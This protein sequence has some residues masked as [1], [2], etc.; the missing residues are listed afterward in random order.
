[1]YT[2]GSMRG[3]E[4]PKFQIEPFAFQQLSEALDITRRIY[5]SRK[6]AEQYARFADETADKFI[7]SEHARGAVGLGYP[8]Y[9]LSTSLPEY[10]QINE[11]E[12]FLNE[13]TSRLKEASGR[14]NDLGWV[15]PSCQEQGSFSDL[16]ELCKP[17][18]HTLFKPREIF[19]AVPDVDIVLVADNRDSDTL[20]G[21]A[22]RAADLRLNVS[23]ASI[24]Q[25]VN[26][27]VE[28]FRAEDPSQYMM[29]DL[30]VVSQNDL[31][32]SFEAVLEG[33]FHAEIPKASYRGNGNW[34]HSEALPI[35]WDYLMSFTPLG[36]TKSVY[37]TPFSIPSIPS[38]DGW[39]STVR[40]VAQELNKK[41]GGMLADGNDSDILISSLRERVGPLYE[42]RTTE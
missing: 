29:V 34:D 8:F 25:A 2:I 11:Y 28:G 26:G 9:I 17:C 4:N 32:R 13:T 16:K 12:R 36:R 37:P 35:G 31:Q 1:M 5:R 3:I 7:E 41:E 42:R 20:D 19:K 24:R 14:E 27:F 6:F 39:I 10:F 21:V 22:H 30:H 38:V 18:G 40:Q 33:D 23:D 15:C